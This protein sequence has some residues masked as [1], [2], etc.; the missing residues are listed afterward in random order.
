MKL[1]KLNNQQ[2]LEK[3]L[4]TL[5]QNYYSMT[6]RYHKE[7]RE[8]HFLSRKI[9]NIAGVLNN[10]YTIEGTVFT[11][12]LPSNFKCAEIIKALESTVPHYTLYVDSTEEK[13]NF[14]L[15]FYTKE[16]ADKAI[17]IIKQ[18]YKAIEDII[19]SEM[20]VSKDEEA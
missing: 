19:K 14:D 2:E 17:A 10:V 12:P 6:D 1:I 3:E 5:R 20:E 15:T 7:A 16:T 13:E 11:L 4:E 9:N 18:H 8:N